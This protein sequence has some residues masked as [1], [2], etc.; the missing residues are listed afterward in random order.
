MMRPGPARRHIAALPIVCLR[1]SRAQVP[2]R[3]LCSL[4]SALCPLLSALCPPYSLRR[5]SQRS[6]NRRTSGSG[7]VRSP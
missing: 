6:R 7:T 2:N 1:N 5:R 3:P 4:F